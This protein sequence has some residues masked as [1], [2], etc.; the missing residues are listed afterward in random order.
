MENQNYNLVKYSY[1]TFFK[2]KHD[3]G[4]AGLN[5]IKAALP[6]YSYTYASD[7]VVGIKFDNISDGK[8]VIRVFNTHGQTI[9]KKEMP[10]NW[11]FLMADCHVTK[12]GLIVEADECNEPTVLCQSTFH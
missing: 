10:C 3:N 5:T 4:A 11:L 2:L 6:K 12:Q 1:T 8:P 9:V 7:A